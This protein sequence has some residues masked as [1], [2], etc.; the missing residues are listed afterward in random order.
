MCIRYLI[1]KYFNLQQ[2]FNS[3]NLEL[4]SKKYIANNKLTEEIILMNNFKNNWRKKIGS[5]LS[6]ESYKIIHLS[7]NKYDEYI[8]VFV[9]IN[10]SFILE[11]APSLHTSSEILEY[12]F[13]LNKKKFTHEILDIINKEYFPTIY[14]NI[15]QKD[16]YT[17]EDTNNSNYKINYWK[18]KNFSIDHLKKQY[19]NSFSIY[20]SNYIDRSY[21]M[22]YNYKDAISY[23]RKYALNYNNEYKHFDNAGGDCTNFV[24]QCIHAGGIKTSSSWKPYSNS[25]VRVN[26]LYYY[27]VRK[28][29][30]ID[31]TTSKVYNPGSIIQFYT[32]E[33]NYFSHSGLITAS[34]PNGDY[35]YCCHSYDKLD[36]PLSEVYP[37][38]FDKIRIIKIMY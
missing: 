37:L 7:I 32:K 28:G 30:G 36:F 25:W 13:I 23:A 16:K 5:I 29:I 2:K 34:L 14:R 24:C 9:K 15:S 27:L 17:K 19:D 26:E 33:K 31:N 1:K 10:H 6:K 11:N 21:P 4:F 8:K 20:R 18:I 35:L 3:K 22:K 12:I 38:H